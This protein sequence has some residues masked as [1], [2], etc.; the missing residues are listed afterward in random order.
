MNATVT[1]RLNR[2][3]GIPSVNA[4]KL[5]PLEAG[6]SIE[7]AQTV[8]GDKIDG[9]DV[10]YKTA[11]GYFV[12][13]GGVDKISTLEVFK[14]YWFRELEISSIWNSCNEK[15]E[16]ARVLILDS[17]INS[18]VSQLR[19]AILTPI[20]NFV[21][22]STTFE[23]IDSQHHGTHCC[24]LIGAGSNNAYIGAAPASK[25]YVGKITDNGILDDSSTIK[26]A[27]K[28]FIKDQYDFDIISISQEL[29]SF[30]SELEDLLKQHLSK[31]RIIIA[32]IGNDYEFKNSPFKRYPG[33]LDCCISV[34]SCSNNKVISKFSM[35]PA[36]TDIF[37]YGENICSYQ[38]SAI[39]KSLSGTS[40]STAMV[41]G[42][43]TL[44]VSWLK[45]NNFSY[46]QDSFR[47]LITKHSIF[48]TDNIK[49]RL[50]QPKLIFETLLKFKTYENKN[51]QS[52]M[53]NNVDNLA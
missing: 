38:D 24:S 15:G 39:P 6:T 30:D 8:T 51:L 53:D 27:L 49:F 33:C 20:Q 45:K 21:P 32:S 9:N 31:N 28:E 3:L 35:N 16:R 4:P 10:W 23:D 22:N 46:S 43:C 14:D 12:W 48:L 40:Q 29:Y 1:K 42:I 50:I 19:S 7:I 25:I 5:T 18:S 34:G 36:K 17:G 2:R 44:I 13:S 47:T 11:E 37:C 52:C 41:A 26:E